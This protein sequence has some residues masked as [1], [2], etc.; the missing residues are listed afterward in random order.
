MA[1]LDSEWKVLLMNGE[2]AIT[3]LKKSGI[4]NLA[5]GVQIFHQIFLISG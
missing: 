1:S 4:I 2:P 3:N 5:E